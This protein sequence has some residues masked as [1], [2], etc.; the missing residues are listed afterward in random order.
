M[1]E[2]SQLQHLVEV[3]DRLRSSGGCPWDAEQTHESLLT[4]LIEESYEFIDAVER[5]DRSDMLE[6]LGDILLQVVFHARIASEVNGFGFD[7]ED[8]AKGISNKLISRHPHVFSEERELTA[9]EVESNWEKIKSAEKGRS[10]A[11]EGVP[12]GQPALALAA[13]L[14]H[15]AKK[16]GENAEPVV[17]IKTPQIVDQAAIGDLLFAVVALAAEYGVD[18][19]Q[20]M[21]SRARAY[22]ESL[23]RSE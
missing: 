5:S 6:E 20:A 8:V 15:R 21:R 13:K 16:H 23:S 18:P 4:Y 12:L 14:I 11:G 9:T 3:M 2:K 17:E 10:S 22:K 7:I 1:I 19:E